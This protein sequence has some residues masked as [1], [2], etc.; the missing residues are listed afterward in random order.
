MV[1]AFA[2]S[3]GWVDPDTTLLCNRNRLGP[4]NHPVR[5][6]GLHQEIAVEQALTRSCNHYFARLAEMVG[7]DKMFEWARAFGFGS[8]TGFADAWLTGT[9]GQPYRVND[10]LFPAEIEARLNTA[11]RGLRNLMLFG[12]GQGAIDDVTPL[13][14]ADAVAALALREFRPPTVIARVGEREPL[15]RPAR[16]LGITDRA[17][18]TVVEGMRRVTLAPFG[19][20]MPDPA[21]GLDLS[22]Y[23]LATKSGTPQVQSGKD[24]SWFVGFFPVERPRFAF[25]LLLEHTGQHGGDV[26]APLLQRLLQHPAFREVEAVARQGQDS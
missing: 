26:C 18:R 21:S 20:A 3:E 24:H 1:A 11:E 17:Y 25:S 13:Q 22:P 19:T 2:L 8:R 10:E 9:D 23:S 12:F 6:L 16:P 7:Y 14:V 5:C 15:G 4:E